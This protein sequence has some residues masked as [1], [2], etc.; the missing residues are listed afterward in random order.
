MTLKTLDLSMN[1]FG[2]D[3]AAALGEVLRFNSCLD[4]LDV[5]SN[6]I[7]NEG[8]S[9]ISKGLEFNESLKFLKVKSL[10]SWEWAV[11]CACVRACVLGW[12][13]QGHGAGYC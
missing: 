9:K 13:Q 11:L 12:V 10:P 4:Y 1:G 3:G 7:N 5:S 6:S 8:I 2:N